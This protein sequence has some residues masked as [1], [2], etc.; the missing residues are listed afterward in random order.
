MTEHE[1]VQIAQL[2]AEMKGLRELL[3]QR[4]CTVEGNV[5]TL[6]WLCGVIAVAVIG[7]FIGHVLS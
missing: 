5:N 3:E 6:Y 4:I 1:Q 2:F 7:A